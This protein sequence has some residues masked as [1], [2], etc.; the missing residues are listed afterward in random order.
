M[1]I[2]RFIENNIDSFDIIGEKCNERSTPTELHNTNPTERGA[3]GNSSSLPWKRVLS[4]SSNKQSNKKI[5]PKSSD[6]ESQY[7]SNS[8]HYI[9]FDFSSPL[10]KKTEVIQNNL[11]NAKEK[12]FQK[13]V[14]RA[15]TK[16]IWL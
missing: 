5:K 4:P 16:T 10:E 2:K 12:D 6:T 14:Q 1:L 13:P 15:H 7:S 3:N 11:E 8:S 9:K